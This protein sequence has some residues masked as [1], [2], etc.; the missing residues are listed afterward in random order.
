MKL[1]I[2]FISNIHVLSKCTATTE[3]SPA[4]EEGNARADKS[5]KAAPD[6]GDPGGELTGRSAETRDHLEQNGSKHRVTGK[7]PGGEDNNNNKFMLF[8]AVLQTQGHFTVLQHKYD[9]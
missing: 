2:I 6:R 7:E 4:E 5:W 3:A 9:S 1:K 8:S